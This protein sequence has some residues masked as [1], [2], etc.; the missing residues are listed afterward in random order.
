MGFRVCQ[1]TNLTELWWFNR[2]ELW[3]AGQSFQ[4]EASLSADRQACGGRPERPE[5]GT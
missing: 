2:F 3:W 4:V 1:I 5:T